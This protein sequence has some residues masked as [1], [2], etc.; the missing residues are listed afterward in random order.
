M[1]FSFFRRKKQ[2]SQ[3][4]FPYFPSRKETGGLEAMPAKQKLE[5]DIEQLE[6]KQATDGLTPSETEHYQSLQQDLQR[7]LSSGQVATP[8]NTRMALSQQP[9][10]AS[11]EWV[12][13]ENTCRILLVEDDQDLSELLSFCL[14]RIQ[15]EVE[16]FNDGRVLWDALPQM[17]PVD[18]IS[19][20]IMLPR[21]DGL[22]L[23]RYIRELPGWEKVSI[24]VA[25]SKSDEATIQKV[26]AAGADEYMTKPI[27]PEAYLA[28]IQ[29]LLGR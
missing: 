6:K 26:L 17:E 19:L 4:V 9:D 10:S 16:V 12:S 3:T 2:R 21:K 5:S 23:I 28:R 29:K 8:L 15:A 14:A 18:L 11:E 27:Q 7:M 22:Q 1:V 13:T 20:D 25:S 24:L